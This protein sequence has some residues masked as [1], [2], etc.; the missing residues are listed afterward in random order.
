MS[1]YVSLA[2]YAGKM[3]ISKGDVILV[4]SDVRKMMWDAVIHK[5]ERD[6]NLFIDG[7]IDATGP[8]GTVIFPTYNWN[9]CSGVPFDVRSTS[10]MTGVVGETALKRRD[11]IRTWHPIY[12]FAVHGFFQNRLLE[13]KNSDS[14][15]L[16]SP[17]AFFRENNVKNYIIDVTLQHCFT[18]AHFVEE[19][20][21]CVNYRYLKKFTGD[22]YD[23][24]G[25]CTSRT[26]S[27]FVSNLD[28][29]VIT[30][31]DPIEEDFLKTGVERKIF[32]NSSE[33]KKIELGRAYDILLD[34][35]VNNRSRKLCTY[36]GQED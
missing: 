32:I 14:F 10:C 17:F 21:G 24:N 30:T 11:F 13:M 7:L 4:S 12:S 33:I 36:K 29:D 20:S 22:Y 1:D 35:I 31:I 2:D 6:L 9:F 23:E 15:G 34:D 26:C 28:L 25:V 19:Q 3:D 8:D 18:F 27:M 16:D 5:D